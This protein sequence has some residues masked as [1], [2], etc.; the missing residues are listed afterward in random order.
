MQSKIGL[1]ISFDVFTL[2]VFTLDVFTKK[3]DVFTILDVFTNTRCFH[4]KKLDVF[5]ARI[6]ELEF[7]NG[8]NSAE[9]L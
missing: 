2:D 9:I 8:T 6:L 4:K 7:R 1:W 3:P 5:T